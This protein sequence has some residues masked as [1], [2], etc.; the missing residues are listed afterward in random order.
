MRRTAAAVGIAALLG[1]APP[2]VHAAQVPVPETYPEA[3][4][5]Y[6]RAAEAGNPRAQYFLGLSYERGLRGTAPDPAAAAAWYRKAAEQGFVDA[7]L[8]LAAL[9]LA[10]RGVARDLA[11]AARWTAA[12]ADAGSAAARYNLALMH[13]RGWG[14]ARDLARA[15]DLYAEAADGGVAKAALALAA[16]YGRGE[17]G[18]DDPVAALM[19]ADVAAA[20]GAAVDPAFRAD[21]ASRL[22]PAQIA[23]AERRARSRTGGEGAPMR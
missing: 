5:W 3:M 15:A 21:L 10:G 2:A 1:A 16:L 12:A 4:R 14:V 9:L 13:E 23:E 8:R 18:L 22:T 17:P 20:S 6:D 11:E 7:Q 19:W